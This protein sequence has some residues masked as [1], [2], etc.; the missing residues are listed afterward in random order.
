[1][2]SPN[3]PYSRPIAWLRESSWLDVIKAGYLMLLGGLFLGLA[4]DDEI[5]RA[6]I[7]PLNLSLVLML[8]VAKDLSTA[9]EAMARWRAAR[10]A[11]KGI[12]AQILAFAPPGVVGWMVVEREVWRGF[13]QWLRRRPNA[14]PR[15]EG[16]PLHYLHKGAYTT[17]VGIALVSLLIELPLSGVI[18][19][20]FGFDPSLERTLHVVM[21]IGCAYSLVWVLGDRWHV[22]SG[23]HVLGDDFLDLQIGARAAATIPI[24]QITR[25]ERLKDTRQQ[26]C[27]LNGVAL[28]D[29]IVISPIDRPN[30]VLTLA[31]GA[32]VP[33]SLFGVDRNAPA[34]V[35]LYVDRPDLLEHRITT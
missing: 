30:V 29:T 3:I 5:R 35:F 28:R 23:F 34:H 9:P 19:S 25:C 33:V 22:M 31:P 21:G 18:A 4:V 26:W 8:F 12:G 7:K 20:V 16:T 10:A 24:D 15:P 32:Q 11:G 2:T 14:S 27:K 6:F 13:G 1:M 17:A